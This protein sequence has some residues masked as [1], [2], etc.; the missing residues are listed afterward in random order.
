[1][2]STKVG[3]SSRRLEQAIAEA[4]LRAGT[5]Q[6]GFTVSGRRLVIYHRRVTSELNLVTGATGFLGSRL[7]RLLCS[8]GQKAR[9]F[10]RATSDRRRLTGLDVEFAEGDITDRDSLERALDGAGVVYHCAAVY[11]IGTSDP[12]RMR[13]VNVGGTKNVLAAAAAHGA[14]VIYVSSVV[15]LGPTGSAPADERHWLGDRPRSAYQA[16]KRRAHELAR[17]AAGEGQ[18]VRIALPVTV[19]GPDDPS[20]IGDLHAW[21]MRG[22]LKV[23]AF[24][25]LKM[26]MVYVDDCAEGLWLIAQRG[27]DGDEYILGECVVTFRQWFETLARLSGRPAPRL[28]LPDRLVRS[29]RRVAER[30]APLAGFPSELV[31]EGL[32]MVAGVHWAFSGD[33]ARR[34][35]G[36]KPRAFDRGLAEVVGWYRSGRA[37]S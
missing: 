14:R 27:H 5:G 15:A 32:G 8:R 34:E 10:V 13:R 12:E 17:S 21:F 29:S 30:L 31:R 22:M 28:Y 19:Y 2:S 35:L 11:E 18:A 3:C 6:R 23:A 26:S 24:A 1:M 16:T 20:R 33:K 9:A 7:T 25:D 4:T 37:S 36:W